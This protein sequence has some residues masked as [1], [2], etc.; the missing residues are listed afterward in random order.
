MPELRA[1]LWQLPLN[2][3]IN[4]SATN[5]D[6]VAILLFR[7]VRLDQLGQLYQ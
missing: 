1:K 2:V 3:E 5:V 7:N 6:V 4:L